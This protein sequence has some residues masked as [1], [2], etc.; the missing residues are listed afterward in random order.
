MKSIRTAKES[1]PRAWVRQMALQGTILAGIAVACSVF[2]GELQAQSPLKPA[3]TKPASTKAWKDSGPWRAIG[4]TPRQQ[5]M[6]PDFDNAQSVRQA[7]AEVT[8]AKLSQATIDS[9]TTEDTADSSVNV[10][11]EV[12]PGVTSGVVNAIATKQSREPSLVKVPSLKIDTP[13]LPSASDLETSRS[14]GAKVRLSLDSVSQTSDAGATDPSTPTNSSNLRVTRSG[15]ITA[16]TPIKVNFNQER[17]LALPAFPSADSPYAESGIEIPVR[18]E[19]V[20]ETVQSIVETSTPIANSPAVPLAPALALDIQTH[21]LPVAESMETATSQSQ[22]TEPLSADLVPAL[23]VPDPDSSISESPQAAVLKSDATVK[24]NGPVTAAPSIVP[25]PSIEATAEEIQALSNLTRSTQPN[26]EGVLSQPG[27]N[28]LITTGPMVVSGEIEPAEKVLLESQ[29]IRALQV[30]GTISRLHVVD[31]SICQVVCNGNR[32]F[33]VADQTGETMIEVNM[34]KM[35][36][37]MYVKVVVQKPWARSSSA[38]V[39][40]DQ[41]QAIVSRLAPTADV[42]VQPT[43]EGSLVVKGFTDNNQQARKVLEAI[44][45]MVLVPV[46]DQLEIR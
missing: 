9:Q 37:P 14:I 29:D 5:P 38:S 17:I 19:A 46:I 43:E 8:S 6:I 39:S 30:T 4:I 11:S 2:P 18:I 42:T 41:M 22:A 25:L 23:P 45:K 36:K 34:G 44:R 10:A 33:I 32:L 15:D 20:E 26:S 40:L 28:V 12:A 21:E 3:S 24:F 16:E 13:S 27:A 1:I 7:S 31:S 35:H